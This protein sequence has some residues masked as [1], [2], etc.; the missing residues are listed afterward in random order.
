MNFASDN[1]AG[2]APSVMA[3][4]A[5]HS[6]GPAPA[7]G[8]DAV[9]QG[10]IQQFRD[11]FETDAAVYYTATGTA[12]NALALTAYARPG[13][14]IFCHPEAHIQVDECGA[15]EFMTGGSKLVSVGGQV[16][17]KI[18]ADGLASALAALPEGSAM[19]GQAAAVSIT[20]ASE[21]GTV[22]SLEEIRAIKA[23]AESRRLPL[24]MDGARFANALVSLGVTPAEM[25][26]KAGVDV[27]S[28][29][30][31]KNGCWCAE[32]VIF[33]NQEAARSFEYLRKRAGHEFS[34]ARFV[35][36]QLEGYFENGNWL[37]TARHANAMAAKLSEGIVASGGRMA[38]PTEANEVFAIIE[39]VQADRLR[40]NGAVFHPWPE[41]AIPAEL[42]PSE[43]EICV[44]LVASFAT[45]STETERFLSLL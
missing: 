43:N 1:W 2:A 22:Y 31:T 40:Q 9:T 24:H 3:A 35:S 38:W 19:H 20:Q 36:A 12:A 21:H 16:N 6:A 34:K 30:G 17:G 39:K 15:A 42:K 10:V 5:R 28:F 32:A 27:L 7:Y 37:Q 23:Q 25:T 44:R 26:W 33:F 8:N 11:I 45:E 13:G 29:G 14:I 4:L 41:H 18:T